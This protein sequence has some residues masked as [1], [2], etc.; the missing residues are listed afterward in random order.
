[1]FS[2][3]DISGEFSDES[4]GRKNPAG[5]NRVRGLASA[6]LTRDY[7]T[8]NIPFDAYN[9]SRVEIN[10]GSNSILFGL[11]SPAGIINNTSKTANY[12]NKHSI[13]ARTDSYGSFRGVADFNREIVPDHLALRIIGLEDRQKFEQKEAFENDSRLFLAF[14]AR[15]FAGKEGILS[16]FVVRGNYEEGR[17]DANRPRITPP[18]DSVTPWFSPWSTDSSPKFTFDPGNKTFGQRVAWEM[19]PLASLLRN[20]AV[21]YPDET[22][23]IPRDSAAT[24]GQNIIGRQF[25]L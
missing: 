22:S 24:A 9:T 17:I 5:S 16:N 21:V 14:D 25:V 2:G 12:S 18:L 7:F 10:R 15:P 13:E 19:A 23:A 1:N 6:D 20:A 8:T 4:S 11:G 3:T